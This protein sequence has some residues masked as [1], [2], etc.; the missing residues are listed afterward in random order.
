MD[1]SEH[2]ILSLMAPSRRMLAW[3][4]LVDIDTRE[5]SVH[6]TPVLAFAVCES[7][8]VRGGADPNW[9]DAERCLPH[10][11]V[12]SED[13]IGS[14]CSADEHQASNFRLLGL[15]EEGEQ[16]DWSREANRIAAGIIREL[17]KP[18]DAKPEASGKAQRQP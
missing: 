10:A 12:A 2:R 17:E 15:A 7:V 1:I 4:V 5:Q 3:Y 13:E 8:Y 9:R 6:S 18:R 16:V 14:L 11:M